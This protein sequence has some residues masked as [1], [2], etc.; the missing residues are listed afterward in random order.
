MFDVEIGGSKVSA[1]VT[2]LTAQIYEAEFRSDMIKDYF[3]KEDI[4]V[5]DDAASSDAA[6]ASGNGESVIRVDFTKTNWTAA[7]KVLWAAIKTANPATPGYG[8]WARK[9]VGVNMWE[10]NNLLT[11]DVID[12]FFRP[13]AAE[14]QE[15]VKQ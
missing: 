2:F 8:P 12:C 14:A 11:Y 13:G 3:G 1:E 4:V 9:V 6:M 5:S 10:V 7:M 15:E